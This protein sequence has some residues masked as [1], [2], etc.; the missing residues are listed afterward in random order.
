MRDKKSIWK[1]KPKVLVDTSFLLSAIGI[2]VE[3]EILDTIK[4]FRL[5]EVYYL[6]VCILEAMWIVLKVV[7]PNNLDVVRE[8]MEA[9]RDTYKQLVPPPEAYIKAYEIYRKG[10]KDYI[11]DLIYTTSLEEKIALLTTDYE[12]IN[13]LKENNYPV[14]NIITPR[15]LKHI[16]AK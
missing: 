10:H 8:G 3:K 16:L 9:I 7:S 4:Y 2:S 5:V 11:D 6:E 13:F 14:D 12:F 15:D 1:A